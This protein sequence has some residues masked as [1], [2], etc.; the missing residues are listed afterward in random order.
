MK[1]RSLTR[2]GINQFFKW[3]EFLLLLVLSLIAF[4]AF[5]PLG[6]QGM[7]MGDD[8][9]LMK[10]MQKYE[11]S[12]LWQIML[13]Y[14]SGKYRPV[15]YFPMFLIF[16][17][18]G[19]SYFKYFVINC[20]L[21][22]V[23]LFLIYGIT[24]KITKSVV[25]SVFVAIMYITSPFIYY[26]VFQLLGVME[27][28]CIIFLLLMGL[29]VLCF[30]E[31]RSIWSVMAT[32]VL[33]A[34]IVFTHERFVVVCPILILIYLLLNGLSKKE[35]IIYIV[36]TTLPVLL[37]V[38]VKEVIFSGS[39]FEGTGGT[40]ILETFDLPQILQFFA[41]GLL[42]IL[43]LNIGPDYLNG[44]G[45]TYYSAVQKIAYILFFL[46][47]F[48]VLFVYLYYNTIKK[49]IKKEDRTKELKIF[50]QAALT[51]GLLLVSGC[52]TIRLEM[53]WITAPYV[54]YCLYLSYLISRIKS[55]YKVPTIMWMA[56]SAVLLIVGSWQY[57]K[58]SGY[59]YFMRANKIAVESFNATVKEYGENLSDYLLVFK[60]NNEMQW[61]LDTNGKGLSLF[62]I[63]MDEAPQ[64]CVVDEWEDAE[65]TGEN[66]K[67][68]EMQGDLSV[69]EVNPIVLQEVIQILDLDSIEHTVSPNIKADSPNGT[70]LFSMEQGSFTIISGYKDVIKECPCEENSALFF[71]AKLNYKESDG[72][73]LSVYIQTNGMEKELVRCALEPEEGRKAFMIELDDF[74]G[75][76]GNLV[77]EV[78]SPSGNADSDWVTISNARIVKNERY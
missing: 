43:G 59:L 24:K 77:F 68:F 31:N 65:I 52:I 70:G 51:I 8:L 14:D 41:M 76:I 37:N 73:E 71:E 66:V 28:L 35:R 49:D 10:I 72:A 18:C 19:G 25:I 6:Q 11:Q 29:S 9:L 54:I 39:F 5:L 2:R 78:A 3:Y 33:E 67:C 42:N 53:R 60:G 17:I 69:T 4:I 75:Q 30:L 58:N 38:F 23:I 56:L 48:A 7:I 26:Q 46:T 45:F 22:G 34:A 21:Q 15:Y 32:L 61:A 57:M 27:S 40:G 16:K 62:D 1:E 74:S 47:E 44:Y 63:Y 55:I 36:L 20:I 64:Y 12:P 50:L 13:E